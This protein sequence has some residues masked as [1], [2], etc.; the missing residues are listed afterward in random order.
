MFSMRPT[1]KSALQWLL[2]LYATEK[3]QWKIDPEMISLVH[4]AGAEV[5]NHELPMLSMYCL[6]PW[7]TRRTFDGNNAAVYSTR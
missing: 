3:Y 4:A 5:T 7:W 6:F 1:G 2:S